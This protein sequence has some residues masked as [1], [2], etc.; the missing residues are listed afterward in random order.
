MMQDKSCH[1]LFQTL[2]IFDNIHLHFIFSIR[3]ILGQIQ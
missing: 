2:G 1:Y 3:G